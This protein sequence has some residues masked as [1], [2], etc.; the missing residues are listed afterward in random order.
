[1][2]LGVSARVTGVMWGCDPRIA[3]GHHKREPHGHRRGGERDRGDEEISL[4]YTIRWCSQCTMAHGADLVHSVAVVVACGAKATATLRPSGAL[5][6][7][8]R[9]GARERERE[10][11]RNTERVSYI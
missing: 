11:E 5:W 7:V 8:V 3:G 4:H 6:T 1:M 2:G 9:Q 10:R